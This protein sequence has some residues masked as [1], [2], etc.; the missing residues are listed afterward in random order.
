MSEES[1]SKIHK[2]FYLTLIN[3]ESHITSLLISFFCASV[4][5]I[6]SY[7]YYLDE[8]L[9][10]L[11]LI[12]PLSLVVLYVTKLI[13][14]TILKKLPMT[15]LTKI[16]HMAAFV[17]ISWLITIIL[18]IVAA[19]V[20][21]KPIIHFHFIVAGM[22]LAISLR[23]IVFTS[24]FGASLPKAILTSFILPLL[25]FTAFIPKESL[26]VYFVDGIGLGFGISF[27]II[28]S[29]WSTMADRAG[30]PNI[31]ST[32]RLLQ[33]YLLAWTDM[34][35]K[36]LENI[37]EGRAC[38][39]N[40]S[41]YTLSFK[42]SNGKSAIVVPDVHP[43]PFYPVGGSNLSYE[44]YKKHYSNS[45]Q[46]VIM[47]SI[48]DHF[49]NLPSKAQVERYL[50]SLNNGI[51]FDK[52]STC[53][54]PVVIQ[55]NK[56]RVSGIVFGK[57]AILLLSSSPY[58]ME[59]IPELIRKEV[60]AYAKEREFNLSIVIDTHNSMGNHLNEYES[61]DMLNACKNTLDE[62]KCKPQFNFEFGFCHSSE[63]DA[64]ADDIGPA[65]MSTMVI[66]VNEKF[67]VIGWVDSN[68][69]NKKLREH[70]VGYLSSNGISMLEICTSDTHFSAGRARNN[71]GYFTF[72]SF[73]N[74]DVVSKWYLEMAKKSIKKMNNANYEL[75]HTIS[76]VK[77]MG[78][79]QFSDYS[80]ALDRSLRVT[81]I[82]F[83]IISV[84]YI[85][86]LV[87]G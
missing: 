75:S 66:K 14:F 33:A 28:I 37:M 76:S 48:S 35:T 44:I 9:S 41:T 64:T 17:N 10:D 11:L 31:G 84:V 55:I 39:S 27:M 86:L 63:I 79:S 45:I 21:S 80:N 15:K 40:V 77:V 16:Y 72:G 24:V 1:V 73:S 43:G 34:N 87:I 2:R 46:V 82:F 70:I 47:H 85:A 30:R 38:E 13:D 68:N 8:P 54:E 58:G 3:P 59:D 26:P 65:G 60:E 78:S 62:L 36:S 19:Y 50:N 12:L 6:L 74:F 67:F 29:L 20:L 51:L 57:V 7:V 71:V 23:M 53:T 52:G 61:N 69:M 81:K 49:L 42:T 22:F 56:A 32:F 5:V 25:F 4:I 83:G 18:G